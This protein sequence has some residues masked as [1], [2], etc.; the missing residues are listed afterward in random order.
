MI[1]S[2]IYKKY[3]K[4]EYDDDGNDGNYN[5]PEQNRHLVP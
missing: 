3:D 5:I 1:L 4:L 2:S